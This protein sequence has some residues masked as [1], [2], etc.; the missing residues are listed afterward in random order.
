MGLEEVS[1]R[2]DYK[3]I[4][5]LL[6]HSKEE[7]LNYLKSN[8]HHYFVDQSNFE[9]CYE[10]NIFREKFSNELLESY[11]EGIKRSFNYLKEDKEALNSGVRELFHQKELFV[12]GYKYPY[13][14]PRVVDQ[15]LKKLGYLLSASQREELKSETSIVFG[16][17]WA[18][19]VREDKIFIAPYST[20]AMPKKFKEQCRIDA[21]PSKVRPYIFKEGIE[22]DINN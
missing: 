13:Q 12:I 15:Y 11:S 21:I 8:N 6:Q 19:E 22:I 3:V 10:R 2:K 16:A 1:V 17:K 20:K 4:R 18:V 5:P 9:P 7:L 14:I